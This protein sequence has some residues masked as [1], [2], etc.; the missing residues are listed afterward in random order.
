MKMILDILK[1]I[2]KPSGFANG[3]TYLNM[4]V[5][6][7]ATGV[8]ASWQTSVPSLQPLLKF[9]GHRIEVEGELVPATELDA[10]TG[11]LKAVMT[12]KGVQAMNFEYGPCSTVRYIGV[13][14]QPKMEGFPA[15]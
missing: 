9:Q 3:G 15:A 11:Q 12:Q 4:F 6:D 14:P 5:R 2:S 7:A 1:A 13:S 10:A 8:T